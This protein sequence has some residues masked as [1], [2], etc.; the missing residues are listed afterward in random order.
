MLTSDLQKKAEDFIAITPYFETIRSQGTLYFTG[1]Y[2]LNT[3]TWPDIDMQLCLKENADPRTVLSV[4]SETLMRTK[5]VQKVQFTDFESHPREGLPLGLYLGTFY[6]DKEI[7]GYWK[8]DLWIL[9]Q[10]DFEKNRVFMEHLKKEMTLDQHALI[11]VIKKEWTDLYGRPPQMASYFLYQ[12][13][14]TE[15][16]KDK[17]KIEKYLRS[18]K[19]KI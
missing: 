13:V 18:Q 4:L 19:V 17:E 12:A 14:V 16:L 11:M 1:S 7:E 5:E 8:L 2:V 6:F 10:A 3:M 15:K 9:D